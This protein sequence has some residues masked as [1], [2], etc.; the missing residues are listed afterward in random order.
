MWRKI[1]QE[2]VMSKNPKY[3]LTNWLIGFPREY[4]FQCISC[5][6][7]GS[8]TC[9]CFFL[10]CELFACPSFITFSSVRSPPTSTPAFPA[11]HSIRTRKY[12][13]LPQVHHHVQSYHA[14]DC[15]FALNLLIHNRQARMGQDEDGD[16]Y[17]CSAQFIT[18]RM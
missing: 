18:V 11:A 9:L 8:R 16:D 10:E 13:T 3:E 12:W 4:H 17:S 1:P 7:G 2:V 6:R 15:T 5:R 14:N